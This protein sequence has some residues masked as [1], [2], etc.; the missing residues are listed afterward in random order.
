MDDNTLW[1]ILIVS[2]G[3]YNAW[4]IWLKFRQGHDV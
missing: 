2:V 3:L 1:A 4:K